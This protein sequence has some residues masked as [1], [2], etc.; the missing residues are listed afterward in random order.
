MLLSLLTGVMLA[1]APAPAPTAL[2]TLPPLIV[3]THTSAACT[4]LHQYFLP[5]GYVTRRNDQAFGALAYSV[6]KFVAGVYPSDVP[7]LAE[8]NAAQTGINDSGGDSADAGGPNQ[9]DTLLYG[10]S[11]ILDAARIRDVANQIYANLVTEAKYMNESWK[12]Y[13][14]GTDPHVDELRQHLQHLMDLQRALADKYENFAVLYLSNNGMDTLNSGGSQTY[15]KL[16][17]RALL[18][19]DVSELEQDEKDASTDTMSVSERAR[20]GEVG[21]VVKGLMDEE[22]AYMPA[23]IATLNSC[24]GTHYVI[25]H[26]SPQPS[27]TPK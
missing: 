7:T 23:A 5:I 14:A 24:N 19:G 3:H 26:P 12:E 8:L 4:A 13:P 20:I 1:V 9:E 21:D 17:L 6:R 2:P 27:A 22:R 25:E 15:F 16:Y 18:L 11:Q 10:P